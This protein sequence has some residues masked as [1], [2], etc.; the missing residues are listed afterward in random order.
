MDGHASISSDILARYAADVA[1]EVAGV[2]GLAA[3]PLPG[4]RGVKIGGDDRGV[5]LEVHL[6]VEWGASIP[7]VCTV[8]QGRVR[9]C[10]GR[11]AEVEPIAVDVVVDEV[12]PR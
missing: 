4:R 3:S 8:V 2:R 9:E 6:V 5:R 7:D 1:Q 12:G 10:L 11:M